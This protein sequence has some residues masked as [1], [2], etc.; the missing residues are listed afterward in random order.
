MYNVQYTLITQYTIRSTQNTKHNAIQCNTIQYNT[1]HTIHTIRTIPTI[2]TI[3]TIHTTC[4]HTWYA[5]IQTYI[6]CKYIFIYHTHW[7]LHIYI[8]II[9]IY[10]LCI[11]DIYMCNH[12]QSYLMLFPSIPWPE[13]RYLSATLS[14]DKS[15]HLV[16]FIAESCSSDTHAGQTH[17][18]HQPCGGAKLQTRKRGNDWRPGCSI[19][20]LWRQIMKCWWP[21]H[22]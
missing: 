19:A 7:Y 16:T 12:V 20:S 8:Y 18:Q 11:V 9:Y 10:F 17:Q 14:E 2:P 4:I 22:H 21:I 1:I 13:R 3:P 6:I 5:N 15:V